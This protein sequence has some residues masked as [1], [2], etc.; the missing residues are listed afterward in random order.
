MNLNRFLFVVTLTLSGL[1]FEAVEAFVKGSSR[2]NSRPKH[3]ESSTCLGAA[4]KK[5]AATK[6]KSK[7]GPKTKMEIETP[8]EVQATPKKAE[9]KAVP[10]KVE[11]ETVRKADIVAS[12]AERM[13]CSKVDAEKALGAVMGTVQDVSGCTVGIV[14]LQTSFISHYWDSLSGGGRG[15]GG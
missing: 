13:D 8:P 3:I 10:K 4:K 5:A 15:G 6:K 14:V 2:M 7:T 1:S 9:I 12:I 11:V